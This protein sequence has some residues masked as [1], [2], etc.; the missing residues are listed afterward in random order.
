LNSLPDS[1]LVAWYG[2]DF[3]GA[4]AVMEVLTFAGI[5]AMLFLD[6][7]TQDQLARYQDVRAIG[8]A[9]TARTQSPAWMDR[10]LPPAFAALLALNPELLHYKICSTL[11]SSPSIGSI[12]RAIEIA[13]DLIEPQGVPVVVA[14]PPVSKLWTS[15]RSRR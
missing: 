3:T 6:V 1:L 11:D 12:G 13:A 10:A 9:S 2:D 7:P 8:V 14:N 15:V 4:A 5:P